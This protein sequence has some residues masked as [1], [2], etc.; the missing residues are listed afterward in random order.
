M[1]Q[2]FA[3]LIRLWIN[4]FIVRKPWVVCALFFV[5]N[6]NAVKIKQNT[7]HADINIEYFT[8]SSHWV[9]M[10]MTTIF[11]IWI[12]W[13]L[14][15]HTYHTK[16]NLI[17]NSY[18]RFIWNQLNN[19]KI[20]ELKLQ[21]MKFDSRNYTQKYLNQ[22]Q[23]DSSKITRTLI[24]YVRTATIYCYSVCID[25]ATSMSFSLLHWN[26]YSIVVVDCLFG[27]TFICI[28]DHFL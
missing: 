3:L 16:D 28:F 6:N 18:N 17:E 10:L 2:L 9:K 5:S 7:T 26:H 27:L 14:R 8:H 21:P 23:F 11:F 22:T 1:E 15:A 4:V 20:K 12:I 24:S 19:R 13:V 25:N